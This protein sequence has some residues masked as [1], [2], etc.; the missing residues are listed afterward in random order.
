MSQFEDNPDWVVSSTPSNGEY[1]LGYN[2]KGDALSDIRVR[3]AIS[4]AIDKQG[5][6][7]LVN[8]YGTIIGG[9]LPAVRPGL[10]GPH[11]HQRLRPRVVQ[12]A[13]R[14]RPATATG[15]TSRS[16][17]RTSTRRTST[18]TSWRRSATSAST[19][20]VQSVEF[21]TWIDQV[22]INHDYDLTA[23]LH[24]EPKD[25]LQ[26][27]Q[28]GLLLAVRQPD[29]A[30]P[31]EPGPHHH[32]SRPRPSTSPA[33]PPARSPRTP[34]ST[35][36]TSP[37]RSSWRSPDLSGYPTFDVNNRFDASGIVLSD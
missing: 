12:A 20:T 32:R 28:P 1:T 6:L 16:S 19:S 9:P 2:N 27:R 26:L 21:P 31:V 36:C 24:V 10:R 25:Y 11:R 30:G 33:R 34:R 5:I 8:G 17:C 13:A 7:E 29:R 23:V 3:Q 15:S 18:T 22:Y 35:G 37:T 14:R 4:R